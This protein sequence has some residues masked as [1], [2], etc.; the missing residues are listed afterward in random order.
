METGTATPSERPAT[1]EAAFAADEAA[2]AV[3]SQTTPPESETQTDLTAAAPTAPPVE[4]TDPIT[5]ASGEPPK[6]RWADILSNARTKTRGD[7]EQEFRTKYPWLDQ[8]DPGYVQRANELGRLF[9]QDRAGYVRQMLA[10]SLTDPELAT[11]V[12]SEAARVLASG[13]APNL[14]PDIPVVDDRGQVVAQAYSADRVKAVVQSAI[15]E[16]LSKE[17]G[18]LKQ[19]VATVTAERQALAVQAEAQ[20][21]ADRLYSQANQWDGFKEHETAIAEAFAQHPEWSLQ[22]A[23]IAVVPGKLKAQQSAKTLDDLKRKAA[24]STVNPAT[25]AVPATNRPR[26]FH[27]AS[28]SWR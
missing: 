10:E 6:E 27:D 3:E 9:Q 14:D 20:S 15:Q 16:A 25:A 8:V 2:S 12:R 13:R 22:D 21:T 1:F 4:G 18:P 24:A 5:P 23:Y 26:S 17:V 28:L 7:V 19:S 11:V